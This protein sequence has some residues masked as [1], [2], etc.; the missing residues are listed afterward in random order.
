MNFNPN[1]HEEST[2]ST[3]YITPGINE[4]NVTEVVGGK[5]ANGNSY[6]ELSLTNREGSSIRQRFIFTEKTMKK[7]MGDL[8]HLFVAMGLRQEFQQIEADDVEVFAAKITKLL[9][10][11]SRPFFRAKFSKRANASKDKLYTQLH[12]WAPFAEPLAGES[13]TF[14]PSVD[15]DEIVRQAEAAQETFEPVADDVPDWAK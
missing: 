6:L 11:K 10:A 2:Q 15:N 1:K 7:A 8:I 3:K 12:P 13:L 9:A 5:T 14:N 4:V